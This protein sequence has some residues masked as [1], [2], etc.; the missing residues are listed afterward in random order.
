MP[1][2]PGYEPFLRAI[3]A[4]PEDDTVRL[5]YADWLDEN[6]DPERAEF[7]RLQIA[8]QHEPRESV[9]A[10]HLRVKHGPQW[11]SELACPGVDLGAFRRGFV[12]V[13]HFKSPAFFR[14]HAEAMLAATPAADLRLGQLG[15]KDV[16]VILTSSQVG[17]IRQLNILVGQ[18]A[19]DVLVEL[20][21]SDGLLGL[22]TLW[23]GGRVWDYATGTWLPTINDR[24]VLALIRSA[25]LTHL[26]RVT[27]W[28]HSLSAA[29]VA[30]FRHRFGTEGYL[31]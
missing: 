15:S 16:E 11:R 6:G 21:A 19:D 23:I 8:E 13:L 3:C 5:V 30:K 10:N 28:H 9:R 22:D 29:V 7:I 14:D 20:A 18:T 25:K 31:S 24:G 2:P 26:R 4:E 12:D 1:P 27:L 17:R